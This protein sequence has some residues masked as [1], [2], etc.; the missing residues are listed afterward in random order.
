M[1]AAPEIVHKKGDERTYSLTYTDENTTTL[2]PDRVTQQGGNA[3][4]F[5]STLMFEGD[6]K[7]RDYG[8]VQGANVYSLSVDSVK[9]RQFALNGYDVF[10]TEPSFID[11]YKHREIFVSVDRNNEIQS[12]HYPE[13]LSQVFKTFMTSLAQEIQVSVR[14]GKESWSTEETNQHGRGTVDYTSQPKPDHGFSLSKNRKNYTYPGFIEPRDHQDIQTHDMIYLNGHGFVQEIHKKE[15]THITNAVNGQQVLD[16]RKNLDLTLKEKGVFDP[17]RFGADDLAAMQA[18]KPGDPISDE[19]QTRELLAK[20]AGFVT[21]DGIERWLEHFEPDHTDNRAN[22]AMFYRASGFVELHPKS[23]EKLADYA[24]DTHRTSQQ[25]LITMNLLAAV[26]NGPAQAAMRDIL[27]NEDIYKDSRQFGILTQNFSFIDRK[28]EPE[29]LDFLNQTMVKEKGFRSYSA[30]HALGASINNLLTDDP[31]DKDLASTYNSILRNRIDTSRTPDE[32]AEYIA[33]LGNAG[34]PENQD[35]LFTCTSDPNERI[36]MEAVMA[37]RKTETTASRGMVLHLFQD[38]TRSVQRSAIQTFMHFH[39]VRDNIQSIKTMLTQD[40]I[41]EANYYDLVNVLKKNQGA[42]PELVNDCYA[43]MV[44]K[45][46]K[47][48]DLKARIRGLMKKH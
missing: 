37:L 40:L 20:Q 17:G 42:Y 21:Y 16:V 22:N 30:A 45:P 2:F 38:G 3:Q 13:G 31:G 33:A 47:D 28:P 1:A 48:P 43:L 24:L 44:K 10:S 5:M 14:Q 39:P 26:G 46:L 18:V 9:K 32:K 8:L 35:L 29:T 12:F 23:C 6:L 34:I 15:K 19:E 11:Q 4:T 36:R 7:V 41:E 27:A 25:R